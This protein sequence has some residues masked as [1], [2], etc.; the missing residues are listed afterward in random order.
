MEPLVY[1]GDCNIIEVHKKLLEYF[2]EKLSQLAE[3]KQEKES[4]T[5]NLYE[6]RFQLTLVDQGV[7]RRKIESLEKI[8]T[9]TEENRAYSSYYE[10]VKPLLRSYKELGGGTTVV[11]FG[12][13]RTE[14]QVDTKHLEKQDIIDQY[15]DIAYQYVD[16]SELEVVREIKVISD[17]CANCQSKELDNSL[18]G[19]II[20]LKCGV[21]RGTLTKASYQNNNRKASSSNKNTYE[22]R[23]NFEKALKRYQ[24]KQVNKL[25][26]DLSSK[27]DRYFKERD[28]PTSE[29][30]RK[31]PLVNGRRGTLTKKS[32][33][34]ALKDIKYSAYYED[35]NLITNIYW[36]WDLPDV[37]HLEEA[38]MNDYD[39]VQKVFEVIKRGR[40]SCLNIQYRLY[41]HLEH[42][43]FP[44]RLEDFK[45]V[46]TRDIL[47]G[48]EQIWGQICEKLGWDYASII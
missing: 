7:I 28:L 47:E 6:R 46:E 21:S 2:K 40:K 24:G 29:E 27:L 32:L 43:G 31:M 23:E 39:Q 5:R 1:K 18:D 41:R 45:I 8:I 25:P 3:W 14:T 33:F 20:C 15:L 26:I 17:Q 38:I 9:E 22:D 4:L 35:I 10:R 48:Y 36:G 19:F 12:A 13:K 42:R 30:V 11:R 44:C 34:K 37:S 16:P